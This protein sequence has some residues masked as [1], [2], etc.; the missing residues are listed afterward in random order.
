MQPKNDVLFGKAMKMS[1]QNTG[2][3]KG[4]MSPIKSEVPQ[5]VFFMLLEAFLL[6]VKLHKNYLTVRMS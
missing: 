6:N 4:G 2:A 3:S 1:S 5:M